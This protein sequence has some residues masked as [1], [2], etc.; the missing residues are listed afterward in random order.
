MRWKFVTWL[1]I[2]ATE[3]SGLVLRER[4]WPYD[5]SDYGKMKKGSLGFKYYQCI[6]S[7]K[8]E[9]KAKLIKHD[10]K[11]LI[12]GYDMTIK[13]ELNIVAFL[14]GNKSANKV[15]IFYLLIC[16]LIVPEYIPKLT[17]HY[18]R[19]KAAQRLKNYNLSVFVEQDLI[20]IRDKLN[21]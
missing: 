1:T 14:L 21:I 9:Y 20:I 12:L 19:G 10:M 11:H 16:L 7:K 15:S 3:L 8:I 2:Q 17:K 6:N 18:K 5:L 13:D 4:D